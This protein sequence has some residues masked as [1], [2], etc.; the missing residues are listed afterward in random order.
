[1]L[2]CSPVT[3]IDCQKT[4]LNE[5]D[6]SDCEDLTVWHYNP[7]SHSL[8]D[9][10]SAKYIL[11][12]KIYF[13]NV[14]TLSGLENFQNLI[15][16]EINHCPKLE[17]I[18][19]LPQTLEFVMIEHAKRIQ[20]YDVLQSLSELKTLRV[21]E[22]APFANISFINS[23]NQL[24]EFRFVNTAVIDGNMQPLIEHKPKL[25]AVAFNNKRHYSHTEKQIRQELCIES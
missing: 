18:A 10:L 9:L 11:T 23:L 5:I 13:T 25:K 19:D 8:V 15:H 1:M 21:H 22:S 20:N 16:F 6:F 14:T 17:S 7:S 3:I 4:E 2:K 24:T 12:L